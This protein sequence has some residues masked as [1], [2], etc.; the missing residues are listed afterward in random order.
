MSILHSTPSLEEL[1]IIDSLITANS[2]SP[3][4]TTFISSLQRLRQDGIYTQVLVPPLRSLSLEYKG[5]A[6]DDAAFVTMISSRWLPDP[7]Y[8]ATVGVDCIRSVDLTFLSCPVDKTVYQPLRYLDGMGL[9]VVIAGV[10]APN[11]A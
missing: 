7:V 9:M 1:S 11:S 3:I 5:K 4:T 6:F 10:K 2:K 8:A